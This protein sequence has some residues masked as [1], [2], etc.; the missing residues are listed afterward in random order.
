MSQTP[1]FATVFKFKDYREYLRSYIKYRKGSGTYSLARFCSN[2]G[3][4][5]SNYASLIVSGKRNLT[6]ADTYQITKF[7]N[8]TDSERK[9]MI[10]MVQQNDCT[11]SQE[12]SFYLEWMN[13]FARQVSRATIKPADAPDLL[14]EW[15]IPAI[16]ACLHPS[17]GCTA[18]V[19]GDLTQL[20]R[21]L[22][23]RALKCL[24]EN[25]LVRAEGKQYFLIAEEMIDAQYGQHFRFKDF[26]TAQLKRS[27]QA[28]RRSHLTDAKFASNTFLLSKHS[29][30]ELIT[31]LRELI[32]SIDTSQ[33]P[34]SKAL[35]TQLNLQLFTFKD[36][37]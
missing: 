32:N 3:F 22:V 24:I 2:V 6:L 28:L 29:V 23:D 18:E 11:N 5:S 12:K 31:K 16:Q 4:K 21:K 27:L 25:R 20:P 34:D 30:Q 14:S 7:L 36:G 35:L 1:G 10:L 13:T 33:P 8:L 19:M 37:N 17:K 26:Q 9:Y 15:Y